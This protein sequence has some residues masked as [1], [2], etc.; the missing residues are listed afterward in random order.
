MP[1]KFAPRLFE[2]LASA[3]KKESIMRPE[4]PVV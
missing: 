3:E 4:L 2:G 1:E